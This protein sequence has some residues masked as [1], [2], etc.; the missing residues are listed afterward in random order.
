MRNKLQSMRIIIM[1][2][3]LL[4]IALAAACSTTA[5]ATQGKSQALTGGPYVYG[6][7]DE[8]LKVPQRRLGG[9]NR[10]DPMHLVSTELG[11]RRLRR[12]L[13]RRR[14]PTGIDQ[15]CIEIRCALPD[16]L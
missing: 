11:Q 4:A 7:E 14:S 10:G 9:F 12:P 2:K 1:T 15:D 5:L 6:T 8:R 3:I 16:R 13:T